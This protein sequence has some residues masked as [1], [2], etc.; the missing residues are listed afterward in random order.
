MTYKEYSDACQGKLRLLE[1]D[2][3]PDGQ[4]QGMFDEIGGMLRE[5]AAIL[6]PVDR[7]AP[8]SSDAMARH[9]VYDATLWKYC[10]LSDR[11][12]IEAA[13]GAIDGWKAKAEHWQDSYEKACLYISYLE[14]VLKGGPPPPAG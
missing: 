14:D 10:A 5:W 6:P 7:D 12:A 13:K 9:L 4:R 11:A 1:C 3:V 8:V 2:L